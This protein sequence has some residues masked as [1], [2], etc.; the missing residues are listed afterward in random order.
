MCRYAMNPYKTH[1]ACPPCRR[2]G[3]HPDWV[4]PRCPAC[5]RPMAD[6]GRDFH[7]PRRRDAGQWRKV[8]LLVAAGIRFASCGCTGPGGRPRTLAD[9]KRELLLR[10]RGPGRRRP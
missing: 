8:E 4:S 7:A 1:W 2:T 6:L 10:G 5:D 3:K 9:A